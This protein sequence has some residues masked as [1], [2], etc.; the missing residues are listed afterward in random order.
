MPIEIYWLVENKA[1]YFKYIGDVTLDEIE[2]ASDIGLSML[3]SATDTLLVHTI[4]DGEQITSFPANLREI[5]RVGEKARTHPKMGWMVSVSVV[6]PRIQF[7]VTM[8]AK[9]TRA[10]QRSAD[11][12]S[13]AINFL[14]S[15]DTT[16][17]EYP[18]INVESLTLYGRIDSNKPN[19]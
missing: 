14:R 9:L 19:D 10:R 13:E 4:Q 5:N 6:D 15:V 11:S 17:A 18:P 1:T 7:I 16:L 3:E 2:I 8:V 12:V